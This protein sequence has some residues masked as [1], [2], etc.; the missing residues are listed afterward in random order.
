MG[1]KKILIYGDSN[2]HGFRVDNGLRYE[3][4][5]R[6]TGVC[7]RFIAGKADLLEE[8]LNGRLTCFDEPGMSF[9][10]GLAYI[11]AC[12]RSHLPLDMICVM[13]GTND[14]KLPGMTAQI[15]A[16][17]AARVLEK[18]REVTL[19]KYPDKSCEYTLI[20]PVQIGGE[21]TEGPF[22][23]EF[24]LSSIEVS[25]GF[26]QAF[27]DEAQRCGFLYFDASQYAR[28]G[29]VDGLHLDVENHQKLGRA[30]AAWLE[31]KI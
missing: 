9:R 22:G 25:K 10:N 29:D 1:K 31:N 28:P 5:E 19:S 21:L 18:A 6:W 3:P 11:E 20:A 8:G 16:R 30:F 14:L 27:A 24:A 7:Q 4:D 23:C 15:V 26:R 12:V 17:N 2:T 13:L